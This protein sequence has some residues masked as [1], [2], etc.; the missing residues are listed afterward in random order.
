MPTSDG[1][2]GALAA[3][4]AEYIK[5]ADPLGSVPPPGTM[6]GMLKSGVEMLAGN[7]A[8]VFIDKLGERL[9]F[10]RGGTR[11]YEALI[12]K[13]LA[14]GADGSATIDMQRLEQIHRQEAQHFEL[15]RQAIEELGGDPTAMT[16]CADLVGVQSLGLMQALNE[17]RTTVAQAL[18]TILIA[19]LTDNAGWELLI[20]L[21]N[22]LGHT[23]I[24]ER[25]TTALAHE[26]EHLTTVKTWLEQ[27]TI[28]ESKVLTATT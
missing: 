12:T 1:D 25:F 10:E 13:C 22:E 28:A 21:A 19:E 17:P 7:R 14:A 8:Q 3:A 15:V 20:T 6:K 26:Q 27:L 16:P 2:E 5:E 11:L 4:R 23:D 9:A 18:N 24:A